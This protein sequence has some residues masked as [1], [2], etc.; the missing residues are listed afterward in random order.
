MKCFAL[1]EEYGCLAL[2]YT[3]C[4]GYANCSFYKTKKQFAEDAKISKKRRKEMDEQL[5]ERSDRP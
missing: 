3:K 1:N 2:N 4:I 5:S